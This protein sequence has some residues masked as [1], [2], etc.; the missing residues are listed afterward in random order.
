MALLHGSHGNLVETLSL[1]Y[2]SLRVG[3]VKKINTVHPYL[4][5]FF[6]QPLHTVNILSRSHSQ[7]HSTGPWTRHPL[8]PIY[9]KPAH[10]LTSFG[11]CGLYQVT[12]PVNNVQAVA[13][14]QAK[15]SQR[16]AR[17]ISGQHMFRKSIRC[18][19]KSYLFHCIN[20]FLFIK[21]V[22]FQQTAD[23]RHLSYNLA[24]ALE[25]IR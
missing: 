2:A 6:H 18:I 22:L 11:N 17:L 12:L 21:L 3:T 25:Q 19:E 4:S 20:V 16:V 23:I 14:T 1:Y 7:M 15:Y 13:L 5:R 9:I 8:H 10:M 24:L